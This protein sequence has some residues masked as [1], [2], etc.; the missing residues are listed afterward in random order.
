MRYALTLVLLAVSCGGPLEE[1][2][3]GDDLNGKVRI[4]L[5]SGNL[6]TG[7][8]QSW[9]AGEGLRILRGL[10][11][12]VAMV[13]EFNYASNSAA[14]IQAFANAVCGAPCHVARESG[15]GL[16]I[17]NGIVSRYPIKSSGRWADSTVGN[18]GFAWARID[19]PGSNDLW[20]VSVHLL[21][22]SIASRA[23]EGNE[24]ASDIAHAVPAGDYVAIG[25]DFNTS[26]RSETVIAN[27]AGTVVTTAPWPADASGNANTN[28]SRAKPYDWVLVNPA[29]QMLQTSVTIGA[30]RFPAGLVADT[31]VYLPI[32]DL[33]PAR[34]TDSAASNMQHM[35]VVRDFV[36]ARR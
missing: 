19:I 35:A 26:A 12:D 14:D 27:L 21:S 7:N 34:A 11:P 25:G 22:S 36:I 33:S 13:Q 23:T 5:V 17:P 1:G 10:H 28:F 30:G 32:A 29:L 18:R 3:D 8:N 9:T 20:V 15:A 24:L 2:P 16:Q 4:R 31:R 6:S